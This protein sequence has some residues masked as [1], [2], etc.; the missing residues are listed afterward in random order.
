MVFK[1]AQE[2]SKKWIRQKGHKL[3]LKVL[4]NKKFIDGEIEEEVAA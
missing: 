1:L 2:T 3:I 4:E